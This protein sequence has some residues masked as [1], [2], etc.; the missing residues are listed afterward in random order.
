MKN[1]KQLMSTVYKSQG[2][3]SLLLITLILG[4][5]IYYILDAYDDTHERIKH[6]V[7]VEIEK[8]LYY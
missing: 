7:D 4:Y 1:N 5:L 3:I 8:K 2:F 6:K